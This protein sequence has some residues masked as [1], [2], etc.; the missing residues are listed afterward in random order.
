MNTVEF[1]KILASESFSEIVE[2]TREGN[3]TIDLHTH[4]FEAKALITS[5]D[6]WITV[7]D[8]ESAYRVG[9]IFHLN[10]LVP[11]SERY[12]PVGVSYLVGRK[13]ALK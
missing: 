5:G 3:V 11:H 12:G 8:V 9:D 10:A 1:R 2:V 6:L 7:D 4:P 13:Q